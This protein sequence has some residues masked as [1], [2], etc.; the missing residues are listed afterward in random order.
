MAT[1][2]QA[3]ATPTATDP[4]GLFSEQSGFVFSE[5]QIERHAQHLM[6]QNPAFYDPHPAPIAN[7]SG[8]SAD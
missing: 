7:R 8:G 3:P 4:A 5:E 1:T 6:R 2:A